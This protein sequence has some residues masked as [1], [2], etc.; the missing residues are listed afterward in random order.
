MDFNGRPAMKVNIETNK[1]PVTIY[2][3]GPDRRT[4]DMVT[5]ESEEDNPATLY[6][7][8]SGANVR[9]GTYYLKLEYV[10]E[11][12]EEKCLFLQGPKIQLVD[13]D[14]DFEETILGL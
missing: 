13:V 5:L 2:L 11:D 4:I 10:I 12:L 8:L 9:P 7:G 3:L 6:L 1:Y 14:F